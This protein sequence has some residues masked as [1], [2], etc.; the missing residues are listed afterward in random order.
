VSWRAWIVELLVLGGG[1][2]VLF[3]LAWLFRRLAG[4][5]ASEDFVDALAYHAAVVINNPHFAVTYLLF[6]KDAKNRAVGRVFPP[7]QRARYVV[8]GLVIPLLLLTWAL[9][10]LHRGSARSMGWMIELM[11]FLVGWHYVKQGFGILTVFSARRGFRFNPVERAAV[12]AHCFAGW[13]YAWA[14]PAVAAKTVQEK[15]VVYT[16]LA[17]PIWLEQITR[18]AFGLSAVALV[19]ALARRWR[20]DRQLPPFAPLL[21]FLVSIW[22][23]TVYSSLDP[24][25]LYLIPALHSL[26]YGYVVWLLRRNEAREAERP[27]LFGKPVAQRL[28]VL[29][30]SAVALA[31]VLF[32]GGP[33][34][35]DGARG[36]KSSASGL[37]ATPYLAVIFVFVNIHHYFMDTV[38]WRRENP[39]TRYLL[40]PDPVESSVAAEVA[41]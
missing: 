22:L 32:R 41:P 35:L 28:T 9:F 16:A 20:I 21:G 2:L 7:W 23:W 1:T 31:W 5:D 39:E 17:H 24:L 27:P 11:F 29:A 3:P 8:V 40:A 6:Y 19:A 30:A 36:L 34:L 4:L 25:M 14:S 26:Q 10:A 38:L 33:S 15:G 37:G 13:A 18:A 12:L